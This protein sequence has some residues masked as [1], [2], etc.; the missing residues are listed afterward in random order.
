VKDLVA[1]LKAALIRWWLGVQQSWRWLDHVVRA[2]QRYRQNAGNYLAGGI[3]FFSFLALF[4]LVLLGV[5][6]AG[7][8]LH[9]RPE[10]LQNL[11]DTIERHAPGEL[12]TTIHTAIQTAINARASVGLIGLVGTLFAGLG[13]VA[14]LRL[15]SSLVWGTGWVKRPFLKA[16][17]ADGVVLVGLGIGLLLSLTLT[18]AGTRLS[19]FVLTQ[20]GLKSVPG[21]QFLTPAVG[22]VMALAADTVIFGFMLIRLPHATVPPGLALRGALLA[23]AGFEILKI[24]GT[25]YLAIVGRSPAVS[26]FGSILGVLIFFNV[27]FRFLLFCMAWIS[28]AMDPGEEPKAAVLL[29]PAAPPTA[30]VE[31]PPAAPP[32]PSPT[33]VAGTLVGAGAAVG[34]GSITAASL[35]RRSRRRSKAARAALVGHSSTPQEHSPTAEYHCHADER[36][37]EPHARP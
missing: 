28:T 16:R 19:S 35:W 14:N 23:A 21:S 29:P 10:T 37:G 22:L 15:A 24:I 31:P 3:A 6:V 32:R 2:W 36:G 1:R 33:V 18:A 25:Y 7:F 17:I 34:A 11:Y 12:G 26:A 5:S 20:T 30:P 27:V 13:W 4:P 8:V 9:A